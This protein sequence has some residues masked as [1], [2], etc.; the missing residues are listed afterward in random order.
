MSVTMMKGTGNITIGGATTGIVTVASPMQTT[1]KLTIGDLDIG[2]TCKMF[3]WYLQAYHPEAID[4]FKAIE[5]IQ[6]MVD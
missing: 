5:D 4:Q 6:R 1:N 2:R 3:L